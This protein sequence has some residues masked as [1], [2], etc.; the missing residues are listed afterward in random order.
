MSYDE[1]EAPPIRRPHPGQLGGVNAAV[2]GQMTEEQIQTEASAVKQRA[3]QPYGGDPYSGETEA[4]KPIEQD[5]QEEFQG[6]YQQQQ[7]QQQQIIQ[8]PDA[9]IQGPQ[10]PQQEISR[11]D[12]LPEGAPDHPGEA[13]VYTGAK[14]PDGWTVRFPDGEQGDEVLVSKSV[15]KATT[16]LKLLEEKRPELP[17]KVSTKTGD[18]NFE[19]RVTPG[20]YDNPEGDRQIVSPDLE[21]SEAK[22]REK[23]SEKIDDDGNLILPELSLGGK[24]VIDEKDG[25]QMLG[26]DDPEQDAMQKRYETL[27][28]DFEAKLENYNTKEKEFK[29][30]ENVI[31]K[32]GGPEFASA[33]IINARN[34]LANQLNKQASELNA[35]REDDSELIIAMNEFGDRQE[36]NATEVEAFSSG[37]DIWKK[38]LAP[39]ESDFETK[40]K[41]FTENIDGFISAQSDWGKKYQL[42]V[43]RFNSA[44]VKSKTKFNQWKTGIDAFNKENDAHNDKVEIWNNWVDTLQPPKKDEGPKG[45]YNEII[46]PKSS[47]TS[48]GGFYEGGNR[49]VTLTEKTAEEFGGMDALKEQGFNIGDQVIAPPPGPRLPAEEIWTDP[50]TGLRIDIEKS[51]LVVDEKTGETT[52]KKMVYHDVQAPEAVESYKT[53]RDAGEDVPMLLFSGTT[54]RAVSIIGQEALEPGEVEK[55]HGIN[56]EAFKGTGSGAMIIDL[57]QRDKSGYWKKFGPA[58]GLVRGTFAFAAHAGTGVETVVTFDPKTGKLVAGK[59]ELPDLFTAGVAFIAPGTGDVVVGKGGA[60]G[61]LSDSEGMRMGSEAELQ[62]YKQAGAGAFLG[63]LAGEYIIGRAI[64]LA[65]K[66][67]PLGSKLGQLGRATK[68]TPTIGFA[69]NLTIDAGRLGIS[70]TIGV[71]AKGLKKYAAQPT[72][73]KIGIPAAGAHAARAG[74]TIKS[75]AGALF[76]TTGSYVSTTTYTPKAYKLGTHLETLSKAVAPKAQYTWRKWRATPGKEIAGGYKT[77]PVSGNIEWVTGINWKTGKKGVEKFA[78]GELVDEMTFVGGKNIPL[79]GKIPIVKKIAGKRVIPTRIKTTIVDVAGKPITRKQGTLAKQIDDSGFGN[80]LGGYIPGSKLVR[81][82]ASPAVLKESYESMV[83]MGADKAIGTTKQIAPTRYPWHGGLFSYGKNRAYGNIYDYLRFERRAD[84]TKGDIAE[85]AIHVG[86]AAASGGATMTTKSFGKQRSLFQLSPRQKQAWTPTGQEFRGK[87]Y[88]ESVGRTIRK[89]G[90]GAEHPRLLRKKVEKV[91]TDKLKTYDKEGQA[92]HEE[93]QEITN[94][95]MKHPKVRKKIDGLMESKKIDVGPDGKIKLTEAELQAFTIW[96]KSKGATLEDAKFLTKAKGADYKF[97]PYSV[98]ERDPSQVKYFFAELHTTYRKNTKRVKKI[99]NELKKFDVDKIPGLDAEE[100]RRYQLLKDELAKKQDD[101]EVIKDIFVSRIKRSEARSVILSD[102]AEIKLVERGKAVASTTKEMIK[103]LN[104]QY[105]APDHPVYTGTGPGAKKPN[106]WSTA[107]KEQ[108]QKYMKD[109]VDT[110]LQRK[111]SV[112]DA[113]DVTGY[114]LAPDR[115]GKT[116]KAEISDIVVGIDNK[117]SLTG[118]YSHQWNSK[119]LTESQIKDFKTKTGIDLEHVVEANPKFQELIKKYP[120][121]ADAQTRWHDLDIR[122]NKAGESEFLLTNNDVTWSMKKGTNQLETIAENIGNLDARVFLWK[123]ELAKI[124]NRRRHISSQ[125]AGYRRRNIDEMDNLNEKYDKGQERLSDLEKELSENIDM[126]R[127]L[128]KKDYIWTEVNYRDGSGKTLVKLQ[129]WGKTRW[130]REGQTLG[131]KRLEAGDKGAPKTRKIRRNEKGE[132]VEDITIARDTDILSLTVDRTNKLINRADKDTLRIYTPK[133]LPITLAENRV[134]K[135]MDLKGFKDLTPEEQYF[136]DNAG[137]GKGKDGKGRGIAEDLWFRGFISRQKQ[138]TVGFREAWDDLILQRAQRK[139]PGRTS[140]VTSD[141]FFKPGDDGGVGA[142]NDTFK[143]NKGNYD[144]W[145]KDKRF[146]DTETN[147]F[148]NK[149]AAEDAPDNK[150]YQDNANKAEQEY[151]NNDNRAFESKDDATKAYEEW[152]G[153]EDD[154]QASQDNVHG[155]AGDAA[156]TKLSPEGR[157]AA[158]ARGEDMFFGT[159][160]ASNHSAAGGTRYSI[161][162]KN[163]L[164]AKADNIPL[165][166]NKHSFKEASEWRRS[167]KNILSRKPVMKQVVEQG[168]GQGFKIGNILRTPMAGAQ[169]AELENILRQDKKR[170]DLSSPRPII[171]PTQ[172]IFLEKITTRPPDVIPK[173]VPIMEPP[174]TKPKLDTFLRTTQQEGMD[175]DFKVDQVIRERQDTWP[176]IRLVVPIDPPPTGLETTMRIPPGDVPEF[177]RPPDT[178][179]PGRDPPVVPP[180]VSGIPFWIGGAGMGGSRKAGSKS[181]MFAKQLKRDI[182]DLSI[183]GGKKR[184]FSNMLGR[185]K[186]K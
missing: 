109:I 135:F 105:P 86:A 16:E 28:A 56:I 117:G 36:Q 119:H 27:L 155:A 152:K 59:E 80:V 72:I 158:E 97:S 178:P 163:V 79:I 139:G 77:D 96:R 147:W 136:R 166:K 95:Y 5:M 107:T 44:N 121:L 185:A 179:P 108:K 124:S 31:L 159:D 129:E 61:V 76:E 127:G 122:T 112:V 60:F 173:I 131:Q 34:S 24:I 126:Y 110:T 102:I 41:A 55:I 165:L 88:L 4:P 101:N 13:P 12:L 90:I 183:T 150:R 50:T 26:I 71:G 140:T 169:S 146:S 22:L 142:A 175:Y 180:P 66:V 92:M 81:K 32:A 160:Y 120:E 137:L 62:Y 75:G 45:F 123:K 40:R 54:P 11:S 170:P 157:R 184:V 37:M 168:R 53:R 167:Q 144:D 30:F 73:K 177:R 17:D 52:V 3:G 82:M 134:K 154:L 51:V 148:E 38:E 171:E 65:G 91:H 113:T 6:A 69:A 15:E 20:W 98:L 18:L 186:K 67:V 133:E 111:T 145:K 48:I 182:G 43:N 85:T 21:K 70:K 174:G 2:E 116:I 68:I 63:A 114:K 143:R 132:V 181:S 64:G 161:I 19:V 14:T 115:M 46:T 94:A 39:L 84:I 25:E 141:E 172:D 58:A 8:Q 138:N 118:K 47:H 176:G 151:F 125:D 42:A 83:K 99:N 162:H 100:A 89:T 23:I 49:L 87:T 130:S 57:H 93:T 10:Q 35:L 106:W 103:I 156:Y 74:K 128:G 78:G 104:K 164:S 1:E 7:Q 9:P 153:F 29:E 149:R 33:E